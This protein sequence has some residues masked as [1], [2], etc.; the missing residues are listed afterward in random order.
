MQEQLRIYDAHLE[1]KIS[2]YL[3][4]FYKVCSI[5]KLSITYAF[6]RQRFTI[7]RMVPYFY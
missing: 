6:D 3:H 4:T 5:Q 2:I 7:L 1:Y